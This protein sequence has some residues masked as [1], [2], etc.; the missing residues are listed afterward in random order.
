MRDI[1]V[2]SIKAATC[3]LLEEVMGGFYPQVFVH[4][5]DRPYKCVS[6]LLLQEAWSVQQSENFLVL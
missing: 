2:Y 1:L 3:K 6:K 5:V 4:F